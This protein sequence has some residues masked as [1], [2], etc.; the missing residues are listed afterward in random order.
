MISLGVAEFGAVGEPVRPIVGLCHGILTRSTRASWP[1][2]FS[3]L[4]N[5]SRALLEPVVVASEYFGWPLPGL[6]TRW[7]N[8]RESYDLARRLSVQAYRAHDRGEVPAISL[9]G[10][11]N[12]AL[13]ALETARLLHDWGLRVD[14]IVLIAAAIPRRRA[15]R[16]AKRLLAAG[17]V[18]EVHAWVAGDDPVLRPLGSVAGVL[19]WP[20]GALGVAGWAGNCEPIAGMPQASQ[21]YLPNLTLGLFCR[22]FDGGEAVQ[23]GHGGYFSFPGWHEL[24]A[25][26]LNLPGLRPGAVPTRAAAR[27]SQ[28]ATRGTSPTA[29]EDPSL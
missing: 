1:D 3:G 18:R 29:P 16:W 25:L 8:R 23:G 22:R 2:E 17:A 11:S 12:G 21:A 15:T 14:S 9:A 26:D 4:V 27:D 28:C 13:I 6:L 19:A 10:H 5:G 24:L 7:Q 20:W